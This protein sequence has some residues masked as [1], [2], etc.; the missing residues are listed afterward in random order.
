MSEKNI[1]LVPTLSIYRAA[2]GRL[3]VDKRKYSRYVT[4]WYKWMGRK[5]IKELKKIY[6]KLVKALKILWENN[7]KIMAGTDLPNFALNPGTSLWEE[8]QGYIEAGLD[9]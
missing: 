2:I 7:V 1:C 3:V 5:K 6:D 4:P 9:L 8:I